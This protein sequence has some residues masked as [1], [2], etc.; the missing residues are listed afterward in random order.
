MPICIDT[1][2]KFLAS[3]LLLSL[4]PFPS[5]EY[6]CVRWA[7]HSNLLLCKE[8]QEFP[9]VL[10]FSLSSSVSL[11]DLHGILVLSD[12]LLDRN[13]KSKDLEGVG[14][15]KTLTRVESLIKLSFYSNVCYL[16]QTSWFIIVHCGIL[17]TRTWSWK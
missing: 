10:Q 12:Y 5:L 6:P 15:P 17:T 8:F 9:I 13:Q 1:S 14:R 16:Q 3:A 2:L 11:V 4:N 7:L